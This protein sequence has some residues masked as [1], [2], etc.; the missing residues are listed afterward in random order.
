MPNARLH[1]VENAGHLPWLD[2]PVYCGEAVSA[3]LA[4]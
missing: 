1:V 4:E 2:Q 3:F